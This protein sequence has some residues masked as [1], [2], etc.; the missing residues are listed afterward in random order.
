MHG[1]GGTASAAA[2]ALA[3][4]GGSVDLELLLER[5]RREPALRA[6]V[7][8]A[9]TG[10]LASFGIT[11]DDNEIVGLLDQVSAM[12]EGPLP[13]TARDIM[14]EN[15]ITA[16]PEMSV[17]EVAELLAERR[18]SGLPVCDGNGNLVGVIS[19]FDLIARSGHTVG[20]VMSRDVVSVKD[21]A[22]IEAV[23]ALLV[24]RRLKR[25]PVVDANGRLV[26]LITRA[27]LVRE[28]AYR[29][30]CK[31]CGH[32]IRARNAPQHCPNC[33]AADRFDPAPPPPALSTCPTCGQ[34]LQS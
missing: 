5:L 7:L 9:P 34:P 13:V 3:D 2:P 8:A 14:T 32:L 28:L 18:I 26:G 10:A 29:W 4:D 6:W 19:E 24:S 20:D 22:K 16:T 31:R 12:D 33:G 23:R 30:A 21:T 25:V 27:D 11:M 1:N 17:H 15:P